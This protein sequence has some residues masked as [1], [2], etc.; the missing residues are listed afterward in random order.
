[1]LLGRNPAALSQRRGD[2]IAPR[3][4]SPSRAGGPGALDSFSDFACFD[5]SF[6]DLRRRTRQDI[7]VT[8]N[9][10]WEVLRDGTGDLARLMY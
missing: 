1:V 4:A 3:R 9:A 8:G 5:H 2:I 7:K 10:L 6:V